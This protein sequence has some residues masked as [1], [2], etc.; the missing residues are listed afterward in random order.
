[1]RRNA[2]IATVTAALTALA[3]L[4][5]CAGESPAPDPL[6]QVQVSG[7]YGAEPLV[8]IG[9]LSGLGAESARTVLL[10]GDGPETTTDS[11]INA[12]MVVY[13]GATK[14]PQVPY[15]PVGQIFEP[16]DEELPAYFSDIFVGVPA[17]SRV[18]VIVPGD[19]M[20]EQ[21]GQTVSG[22]EL[23]ENTEASS[24][25]VI[26]A[27]IG[28]VPGLAAW[29]EEQAPA[30]ELVT[31]TDGDDGEPHLEIAADAEPPSELVLDVRKLGDGDVVAEGDS[32]LVQYRGVLFATG[33]EFDSTWSKGGQP[34]TLTTSGVIPG[35]GQ[36]IVGQTVGSQVVAIIPPDQAYGESDSGPIPGGST[37]VFV[38]DILAVV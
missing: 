36:A 5:G 20:V 24:P 14:Q 34:T 33:E 1:M 38:I 29:G 7:E 10:E 8:T 28:V 15:Q 27:D 32:V 18:L 12:S 16:G 22:Q 26:I 17:G 11:H 13:D 23:P 21:S 35:F 31:V 30:Q 3:L 19:L 4:A 37:L 2:G 25:A 9:D 6:T